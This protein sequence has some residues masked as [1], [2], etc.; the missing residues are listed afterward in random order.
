MVQFVTRV[1]EPLAASVDELVASGLIGSR[2]EAVRVALRELISRHQR[3]RIGI[4]IVEAYTSQPQSAGEV[5][6]ADLATIQ[7]IADES[8]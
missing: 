3:A 2:S 7:M 6:W 4:Q 1:D 5:G 8:W